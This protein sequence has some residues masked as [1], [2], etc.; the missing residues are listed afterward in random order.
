M[1]PVHGLTYVGKQHRPA[2]LQLLQRPPGRLPLLD[3]AQ[4]LDPVQG[5]AR[6][7]PPPPQ[8]QTVHAHAQLQTCRCT[9]ISR[10]PAIS[11]P[12]SISSSQTRINCCRGF[13]VVCRPKSGLHITPIP[14]DEVTYTGQACCKQQHRTCAA[15]LP[16]QSHSTEPLPSLLVLPHL[17][18]GR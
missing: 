1:Q 15:S 16:E 9:C 5:V 11:G 10:P 13:G 18:C 2:K 7:T 3:A 14:E 17:C 4:S 12:T 8:D 6:S